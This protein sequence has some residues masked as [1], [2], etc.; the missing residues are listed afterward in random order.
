MRLNYPPPGKGTDVA[1]KVMPSSVAIFEVV[2]G[3]PEGPDTPSVYLDLVKETDFVGQISSIR[4]DIAELKSSIQ[5]ILKRIEGFSEV[6][7]M[8]SLKDISHE[9]AKEEIAHFFLKHDG[10]EIGYEDLQNALRIDIKT[11]WT[12]CNELEKEGKIG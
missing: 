10:E 8:V 1:G 5:E 4:K 11:I 2:Q 7:E 12:V 6:E 3:L 9:Q